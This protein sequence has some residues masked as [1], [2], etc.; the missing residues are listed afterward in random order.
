MG[1]L[2]PLWGTWKGSVLHLAVHCGAEG[3]TMWSGEGMWLEPR[4]QSEDQA[5]HK[6]QA[7]EAKA[8]VQEGRKPKIVK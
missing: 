2:G 7:V 1:T 4:H 3:H 8:G 5:E 6:S